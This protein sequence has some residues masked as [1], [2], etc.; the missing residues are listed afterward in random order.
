MSHVIQPPA[1][2]ILG[3]IG[4]FVAIVGT[5]AVSIVTAKSRNAYCFL[6]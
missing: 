2:G 3:I 6:G 1:I 4:C 5:A